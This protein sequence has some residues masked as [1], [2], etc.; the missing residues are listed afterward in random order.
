MPGGAIAGHAGTYSVFEAEINMP[1]SYDSDVPV[2][3]FSINTW[4]AENAKFDD[5]GF[6]FDITGVTSGAGDFFYDSTVGVVDGW[7][8][9]RI[10]GATYYLLLADNQA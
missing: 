4:G 7:L 5:Y 1:T 6:L 3:V 2:S 9:C 10:N 8:K